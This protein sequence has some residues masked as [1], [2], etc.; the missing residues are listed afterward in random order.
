MPRML[1][2]SLLIAIQQ[3]GQGKTN[4]YTILRLAE[5]ASLESRTSASQES[6]D[7]RG[8]NTQLKDQKKKRQIS[9]IRIASPAVFVEEPTPTPEQIAANIE[10]IRKQQL[11]PREYAKRLGSKR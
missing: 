11:S 4:I 10:R 9:N 1:W 8:N 3:R 5:S 6:Q 7:L 2:L